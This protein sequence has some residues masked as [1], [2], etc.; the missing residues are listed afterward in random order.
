MTDA[1]P[2]YLLSSTPEPP[3]VDEARMSARG[4]LATETR[5]RQGD[6]LLVAG[7]DTQDHRRNPVSM[8]DHGVHHPLPIG[9]TRDPDSREYLV[10]IDPVRGEVWQTTFFSQKSDVAAQIFALVAEDVL[11]ANSV[12]FMPIEY[13]ELPA[14]PERGLPHKQPGKKPYMLVTRS[15]LVE[16]SWC[17]VPVN[18]DAVRCALSRE[19]WVGKSLVPE[20]RQM[21]EPYLPRQ[22]YWRP[23]AGAS[24]SESKALV[25]AYQARGLG[26]LVAKS[27][28]ASGHE[29]AADGKFGTGGASAKKDDA[30]P[31]K[32]KQEES[33]VESPAKAKEFHEMTREEFR[34]TH[35][36]R[37]GDM[38]D[39]VKAQV[40][41][42]KKGKPGVKFD[43]SRSDGSGEAV[44]RD[45]SGKPVAVVAFSPNAITD[46]AALP[47]ARGKGAI[48]QLLDAIEKE[49]GITRIKGP[50]TEAG[51]AVAHKREVRAALAAGKEVPAHVIADYPD[52]AAKHGKAHGG[53]TSTKSLSPADLSPVPS[54]SDTPP[55]TKQPPEG[56]PMAEVRKPY[57]AEHLETMHKGMVNLMH[58]CK[59][60]EDIL[61]NDDVKEHSA[62]CQ[63]AL[64]SMA[65]DTEAVHSEKYPHLEPL[66]HEA[67]LKA[68]DPE[69]DEGEETKSLESDESKDDKKQDDDKE[70]VEGKEDEKSEEGDEE[71]EKA[72]SALDGSA[73]GSLVGD[74]KKS[75]EKSTVE[76]GEWREKDKEKEEKAMLAALREQNDRLERRAVT[77]GLI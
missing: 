50:Y 48:S 32:A 71:D 28:D 25:S 27:K 61:D 49:K 33:K 62:K 64:K 16:V 6:V 77:L 66:D 7:L 13:D 1:A 38:E 9:V 68:M 18:P 22:K 10:E 3:A 40:G 39:Y 63:E 70:F 34:A 51:A 54:K 12:G 35:P 4:L 24:V 59:K 73:G 75:P 8:I 76:G 46:L 42:Y 47:K 17:G 72:M 29:H 26:T 69:E 36:V 57:G 67:A 44:F 52:L 30:K 74:G 65:A 14:D 11:R 19:R 2:S 56:R 45:E 5:D 55:T 21:L 37:R 53:D 41:Q 20:I 31:A 43:L 60:S 58:A 23:T 15:Q